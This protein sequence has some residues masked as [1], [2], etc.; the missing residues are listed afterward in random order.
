MNLRRS[1]PLASL[2]TALALAGCSTGLPQT[3]LEDH[4]AA[5][6]P[7]PPSPESKPMPVPFK[8][9]VALQF[10]RLRG[11][12]FTA[13]PRLAWTSQDRQLL[14]NELQNAVR[15]KA[16]SD[17]FMLSPETPADPAALI[18]A[19]QA[20]GANAILVLRAALVVDWYCNPVAI[21]DPTFIGAVWLPGAHRDV[22]V[23][24]RADLFNLHPDHNE[25]M[26]T[27]TTNEVRKI[28][29]PQLVINSRT[30]VDPARRAALRRI[31]GEGGRYLRQQ[32]RD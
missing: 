7:P 8:L 17:Y 2:M 20:Q 16:L 9:A 28:I 25:L 11:E 26:W 23:A 1:L 13:D 27:A 5:G 10:E 30:A 32:C 4:L 29:G 6:Y 12:E 3:V 22:M 31:L 21:L 18:A 19:A 24:M 14:L 15:V